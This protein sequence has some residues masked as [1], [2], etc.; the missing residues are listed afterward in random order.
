[1]PA[2][3]TGT[4]LVSGGSGFIGAHVCRALLI[5]GFHVRTT[6]RSSAKGDYLARKLGEV[7]GGGGSFEYV[8][9]EDI[10]AAD[11]FDDAVKGVDGI[12]HT[13]SPFQ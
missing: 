12:M 2:L 13:A 1:M 6:V 3:H 5:A 4:I 7:S 9:V 10:E 11:A 8:I